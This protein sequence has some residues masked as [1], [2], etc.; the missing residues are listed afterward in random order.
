MSPPS[1]ANGLDFKV[2]PVTLRDNFLPKGTFNHRAHEAGELKCKDCHLAET[3]RSSTDVLLPSIV[4]CQSC[5]GGEHAQATVQSTCTMCHG[6]H[7]TTA[8]ATPMRPTGAGGSP[9]MRKTRMV[10]PA[11]RF[12]R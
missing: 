3:S 10:A 2:A 7:A 4:T 1:T 8:D 11:F 6:F 9:A 12:F 5:H